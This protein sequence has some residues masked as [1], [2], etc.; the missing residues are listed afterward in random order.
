MC[1]ASSIIR[2]FHVSCRDSEDIARVSWSC[3]FFLILIETTRVSVRGTVFN[4]ILFK[5]CGL[6]G[7]LSI[8][9]S[10]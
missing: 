10:S 6:M 5:S 8:F 4:H 7:V 3:A 9:H 1:C 2:S